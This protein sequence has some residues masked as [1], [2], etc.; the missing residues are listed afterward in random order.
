M[1]FRKQILQISV[2]MEHVL[3]WVKYGDEFLLF[4]IYILTL[5]F[6]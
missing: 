2:K 3:A 5:M 4:C 1:I 6:Y